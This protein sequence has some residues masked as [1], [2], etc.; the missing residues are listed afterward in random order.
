MDDFGVGYSS[1]NLIRELPWNVI[2]VDRSFLPVEGDELD[3]VSK[4]MFKHVIAMTNEMGIESIVEG[5]ETETQ[6]NMLRENNCHYAQGF[7]FD[8]PLPK[9]EFETKLMAGYYQV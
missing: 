4:V 9:K 7:L 8:R 1:L 6:L 5:V 2:K 3:N